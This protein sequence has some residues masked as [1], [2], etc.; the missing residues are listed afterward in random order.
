MYL[1]TNPAFVTKIRS[2]VPARRRRSKER[3]R[4]APFVVV[5][6][7]PRGQDFPGPRQMTVIFA[8]RGPRTDSRLIDTPLEWI[9]P[10]IRTIGNGLSSGSAGRED[11]DASTVGS[12]SSLSVTLSQP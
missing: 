3:R 1:P 9:R 12:D 2:T 6:V 11:D 8:P 4:V 7:R 10:L 5:V